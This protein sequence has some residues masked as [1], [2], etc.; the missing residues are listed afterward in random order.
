MEYVVVR[1]REPRGVI[2]DGLF[3]GTVDQTIGV[4]RGRHKIELDGPQDY[5][6]T[7]RL[8]KVRNTSAAN[9]MEVTFE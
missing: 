5:R 1:F 6:P 9:P 7:Y 3:N 2:V 8:P 4:N